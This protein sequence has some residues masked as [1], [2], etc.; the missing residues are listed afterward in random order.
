MGPPEE[1][2]PVRDNFKLLVGA[3]GGVLLVLLLFA[4]FTGGGTGG[5][6]PGGGMGPPAGVG[7][8]M[9][10]RMMQGVSSM[11]GGGTAGTLF[12]L[13]FWILVVA[14]IAVL[15]VWLARG[16]RR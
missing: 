14:L 5:M 8:G 7:P 3:L 11:M 16:S 15:V 9:G 1:V 6:G 10:S 2:W 4:V 12:T 13:L